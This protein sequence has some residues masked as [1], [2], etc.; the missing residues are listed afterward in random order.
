M[1]AVRAQVLAAYPPWFRERYGDELAALSDD[2]GR[3]ARA[4]ADLAVGAA[5]AWARPA[6]AGSPVEVRRSRLLASVSTVWVCWCVVVVGT[7]TTLRLLEDPAAPGLDVQ[8][9]GWVLAGHVATAA[10]VLAAVLIAAAGAVPGWRAMRSS[11][12]VR[13]LMTGPL[14]ALAL[15]VVGF[16]PIAV[17]AVRTPAIHDT[18]QFPPLF[19]VGL[20]VWTLLVAVTSIWWTIAIPRALRASRPTLNTLRIP[21]AVAGLVAVLL[22]APAGL[23]AAVTIATGTAWGLA[24]AVVS[25][26]CTVAVI[27]AVAAGLISAGRGLTALNTPAPRT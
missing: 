10:N 24:A 23:L 5:R 13:R 14:A 18:K 26:S 19:A 4:T 22:L 9:P 2:H 17:V 12:T 8:T 16:I 15:V 3:S 25:T 21:G 6:F 27:A 1:R 11:P 20:L 7:M